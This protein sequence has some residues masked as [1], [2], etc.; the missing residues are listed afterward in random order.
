M[1]GFRFASG[2]DFAALAD[3]WAAAFPGD[4]DFAREYAALFPGKRAVCVFE[5]GICAAMAHF[6]DCCLRL[7]GGGSVRGLY[8]FGVASHPLFRNRGL[9]SGVMRRLERAAADYGLSFLALMPAD[10]GLFGF[11][12]RLGYEPFFAFSG[13][14]PSD[15]LPGLGFRRADF[16]DAPF[17][18]RVYSSAMAGRAFVERTPDY[19][20][21]LLATETAVV[22]SLDGRDCGYV[23]HGGG[24]VNEAFSLGEAPLPSLLA[25]FSGGRPFLRAPADPGAFSPCGMIRVLDG[26]AAALE[27]DPPPY[28]NMAFNSL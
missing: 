20:R 24:I 15:P 6:M 8:V 18:N 13:V 10:E 1:D 3:L 17:M 21:F 7:P 28:L 12:G 9:A 11:Y 23:F 14:A 2:G 5:D 22:A 26:S 19:W 25:S 27:Q 4:G 16:S